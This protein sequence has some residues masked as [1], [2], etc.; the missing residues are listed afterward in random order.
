M[1]IAPPPLSATQRKSLAIRNKFGVPLPDAG[2]IAKEITGFWQDI[3]SVKGVGIDRCKS[4]LG[5]FFGTKDWASFASALVKRVDIHLV[6]AALES[7]SET[8]SPG[9]DG[10]SASIYWTFRDAFAPQMLHIFVAAMSTG[11]I[12]EHWTLALLN[13]I[14]KVP[15]IGTVSDW[16]PLVLQNTCLKWFTAI[17]VLQ[18]QD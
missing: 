8:S 2:A 9:I 16:R 3:M 6:L 17:I 4:Y 11:T 13:L 18:L 7:L 10:V 15:G 5:D 12:P 1:M 14:P